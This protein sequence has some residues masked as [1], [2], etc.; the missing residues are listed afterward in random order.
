MPKKNFFQ[1]VIFWSRKKIFF[2]QSNIFFPP[3]VFPGMRIFWILSGALDFQIYWFFK[4]KVQKFLKKKIEKN[5]QPKIPKI[6]LLRILHSKWTFHAFSSLRVQTKKK[7]YI[8]FEKWQKNKI[9]TRLHR[10]FEFFLSKNHREIVN[11]YRQDDW[12][13]PRIPHQIYQ[14]SQV[15]EY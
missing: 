15:K 10:N 14:Y 9:V 12:K 1:F 3:T 5:F 6:F 4:K 13:K 7:Y 2:F 8:N 11:L